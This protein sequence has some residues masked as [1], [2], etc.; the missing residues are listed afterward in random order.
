M[1]TAKNSK[2]RCECGSPKWR[3]AGRSNEPHESCERPNRL[4]CVG[5]DASL[6]V[7]CS[8]SSRV[9]CV[10]CSETYRRR[11]RRVF[12]SGW[13]DRPTDRVYFL[14][15][16]A[17]G[18]RRH[19]IAGLKSAPL[20][21]CTPAGGVNL[22]AWNSTAG[23]RFNWFMTYLRRHLGD[24]QY[25]RAAECQ[26]RGALH[27]HVLVR[28]PPGVAMSR[29][30]WAKGDPHCWLRKL[31][32]RW[33]FGC[34]M[35]LQSVDISSSGAAWY[36]AKYA[37]KSVDQRE[38][39]PWLDQTGEVVSGCSR[40]R[41]WSAS[42][43]WG[44]TMAAIRRA[45]AAWWSSEAARSAEAEPVS[46]AATG[47]PAGRKAGGALDPSAG[48]Y[49]AWAA[50]PGAGVVG[51]HPRIR[52]T[53]DVQ[54]SRVPSL[55]VEQVEHRPGAARSPAGPARRSKGASGPED[56]TD[57]FDAGAGPVVGRR[58]CSDA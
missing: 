13:Q 54:S 43:R 24:V 45:Q 42:R 18:V 17:P 57:T 50:P 2:P 58:S 27:F 15:L 38:Q 28:L 16:T 46:A 36:C 4:V 19:R 23:E 14:T 31:A 7:R 34:V 51:H 41:V 5:C 53:G 32:M 39:L 49:T 1:T 48:S 56:A 8:R 55:L 12:E 9:A 20:C 3:F 35:D 30:L 6:T 25:A 26:Q 33:G 52:H 22:A 44:L 29:A 47:G 11:V 40:Y 10:P 21:G 37:S